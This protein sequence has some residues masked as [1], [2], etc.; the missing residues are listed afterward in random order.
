MGL[1][2]ATIELL[3]AI[4]EGEDDP[5]F[6]DAE[7]TPRPSGLPVYLEKMANLL[8]RLYDIRSKLAHGDPQAAK[9]LKKFESDLPEL[10]KLARK[11]LTMYVL[12]MSEH[13]RDDW[14][15]HVRTSLFS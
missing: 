13:S 4:A 7:T 10:D 11:I 12:Y 2:K 14:K 8:S 5:I 1:P 15:S 6:E 3:L 9:Q